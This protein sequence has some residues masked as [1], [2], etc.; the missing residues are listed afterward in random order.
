MADRVGM[1][2][3]A[4]AVVSTR[5][6]ADVR[7][8]LGSPS[9]V[10]FLALF[11]SQA[12]VVVLSPILAD[13][14]ADLGVS[15][16]EAGQLRILAAPLAAVV[17]LVAGWALAR[18]SPR[19]LIAFGSAFLAAGSLASAAAPSF[20]LLALAQVPMWIGVAL[21]GAA[22]I[23]ATA[24]WSEPG[25]RARVVAHAFAGPPAAW[26]VGTPLIGLVAEIHWRLAFLAVPLPAALAAALSAARR[27]PDAPIAGAAAS[28]FGLLRVAAARRWAF[29]ELL[30]NAGWAGTSV[31]SG[32]LLAGAYGL[33]PAGTGVVLSLVAG[34]YLVG[35]Q[36]AGRVDPTQARRTMVEGSLATAIAVAATWSVAP[37]AVVTLLLFSAAGFAAARRTVGST[38]HGFAVAGGL[39]REVG[40]IRAAASQLGYLFGSL[41]G[42]IALATGGFHALALALGGL[43]LAATILHVCV[44]PACRA[45]HVLQHAA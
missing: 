26:I 15:V 23:A 13:V 3:A 5:E 2:V 14:A 32:V 8:A 6:P 16:A 37:G 12:G 31:F 27:G 42:G 19:A 21:L 18:R 38:V 33:S 22:G 20:A 25:S 39:G 45:G 9:V 35:N 30:A 29:S 1:S 41:I 44:R 7:S 43:F 10:L 34:A 40:S 28:L 4:H 24:A 17:A 11:A 36:V